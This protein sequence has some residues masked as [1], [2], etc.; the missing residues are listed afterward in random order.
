MAWIIW[1]LAYDHIVYFD[2]SFSHFIFSFSP[3]K[4][5]YSLSISLFIHTHTHIYLYILFILFCNFTLG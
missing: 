5:D 2:A 4:C 3:E 1:C